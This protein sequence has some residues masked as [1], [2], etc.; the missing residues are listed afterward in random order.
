MCFGIFEANTWLLLFLRWKDAR[1]SF[2]VEH[3]SGAISLLPYP[4]HPWLF[5]VQLTF[6]IPVGVFLFC[7]F[8]VFFC[9]FVYLFFLIASK[10]P[11]LLLRVHPKI[12]AVYYMGTKNTFM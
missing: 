4:V 6:I 5:E 8:G 9:L 1:I 11:L 2:S 3:L 7:F 10:G 12:P